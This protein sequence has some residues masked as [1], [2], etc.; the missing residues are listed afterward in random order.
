M[1]TSS[2][3][4]SWRLI[5]LAFIGLTL[6]FLYSLSSTQP[7]TRYITHAFPYLAQIIPLPSTHLDHLKMLVTPLLAGLLSTLISVKPVQAWLDITAETSL[8]CGAGPNDLTA[9]YIDLESGSMFFTLFHAKEEARDKGLVIQFGGGPGATS[10]DYAL[11]GEYHVA[12]S[13]LR[14]GAGSDA[15]K[16]DP[17]GAAPCQ[18]KKGENGTLEPSPYSWTEHANVL[19]LDYPIGAGWSYNNADQIA[20]NTSEIAAYDFD[21]FLQYFLTDYPEYIE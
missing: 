10:W 2:M 4:L 18:L 13:M 17:V 6:G 7:S 19:F 9:G 12:S 15:K 5:L 3:E 20:P 16:A 21:T 11:L 8:D 1:T 14:L